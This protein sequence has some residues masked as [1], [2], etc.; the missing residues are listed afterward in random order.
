[1]IH[2]FLLFVKARCIYMIQINH[3]LRIQVKMLS[4]Q[5]GSEASSKKHLCMTKVNATLDSFSLAGS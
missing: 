2:L 4:E 3:L 5:P 1:M